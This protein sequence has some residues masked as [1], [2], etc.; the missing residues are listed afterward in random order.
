MIWST[1]FEETAC[2]NIHNMS[3]LQQFCVYCRYTMCSLYAYVASV[4]KPLNTNG[5]P[6]VVSDRCLAM[7]RWT[8]AMASRQS[9][10]VALGD[11]NLAS[12]W[13]WCRASCASAVAGSSCEGCFQNGV[14]LQETNIAIENDHINTLLT[15]EIWWCSI[16]VLV[17]QREIIV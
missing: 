6:L 13:R 2:I 1:R 15:H 16:V 7:S 17:D 5:S 11:M 3:Y 8:S 14:S 9:K 4:F 12:S 10:V